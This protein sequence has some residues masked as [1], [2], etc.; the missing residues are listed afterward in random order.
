MNICLILYVVLIAGS[1]HFHTIYNYMIVSYRLLYKYLETT[2]KTYTIDWT[3]YWFPISTRII[4]RHIICVMRREIEQIEHINIT[5][6]WWLSECR[7][8]INNNRTQWSETF[9]RAYTYAWF[10]AREKSD[11]C[12]AYLFKLFSQLQYIII[13]RQAR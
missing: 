10:C 13:K 11:P 5:N 8:G 1:R 4:V 7:N 2:H 9:T 6:I 3:S 12:C